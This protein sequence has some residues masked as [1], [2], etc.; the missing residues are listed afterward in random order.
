MKKRSS[1]ATRAFAALAVV[2]GFVLVFVMFSAALSDD[3]G[4]SGTKGRGGQP[5][6][7]APVPKKK[8][9][10]VYEVE[11]G[12][13]LTSIAHSTGVSV[14]QIERLN[15]GVDPQ[16]LSTGEELKLK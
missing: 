11:E 13:T 3:D 1:A 6:K 5:T 10:A 12:D 15:P 14:A 8:L 16:L 9:P 2:A 4:G 7:Q